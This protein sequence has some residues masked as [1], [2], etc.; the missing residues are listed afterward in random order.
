MI[1]ERS[2][3]TLCISLAFWSAYALLDSAGSL[4][5]QKAYGQTPAFV[6]L[7]IWNFADAYAWVFL[8]P[9]IYAIASRYIFSRE[10]WKTSLAVH[11]AIAITISAVVAWLLIHMNMAL[12]WA[13]TSSPFSARLL[14][15][16]L[17][18]LPRCL[19]TMGIAHV[20]GY[21]IRLGHRELESS[22]LETKLAQAQMAIL[23]SQLEPHFLFNTL[24]SIAA[25]TRKDPESAETMT[26]KLAALLRVSLECIGS[27][28]VPLRQELQFLQSYLDI[29][30]TRFRDRLT[31]R[32]EIDPSLLSTPIPS[33]ILQP[34]VENSIRHGIAASAAPGFIQISAIQDRGSMR[35]EVADNGHG[36]ACAEAEEHEGLGL[37]NTKARLQQLYGI[38]HRF[39]IESTPG[40]GC[41]VILGMPFPSSSL[42]KEVEDAEHSHC[43][44]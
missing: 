33:L 19:V 32:M 27:Q 22:R 16:G 41:R 17:E 14:D 6:H 1:S 9:L 26:L 38:N 4:A 44:C 15:L 31:V 37:R 35:I 43:D 40:V 12:N 30:Q 8:T 2:E 13:D 10:A 7:L 20:L 36:M 23:R 34:L 28:E 42:A 21:Y 11:V 24:N 5:I 18:I 3:Q 29:Q 39:E 25:L